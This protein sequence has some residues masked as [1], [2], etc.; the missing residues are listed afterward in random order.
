MLYEIDSTI[1]DGKGYRL[2]A[3]DRY[4]LSLKDVAIELQKIGILGYG[5]A[6]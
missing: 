6:A 3:G 2:V 1:V 5:G 4:Q